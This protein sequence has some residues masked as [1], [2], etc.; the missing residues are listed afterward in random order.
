MKLRQSR[1]C[2]KVRNGIK[3]KQMKHL[4]LIWTSLRPRQWIKNV[5]ILAP[6]IFADHLFHL[7]FLT[8]TATA[9]FLFSLLNGAVYLLND[10]VDRERDRLH[11]QKCRRPVAAGL[12]S[13][14]KALSAAVF[15]FFVV[16]SAI[17][18]FDRLFFAIALLYVLLNLLY[19]LLL[20]NV[21]ICDIVIIALGFVL[22]VLIGGTV[23]DIWLSPWIMIM[24]FLLAIFLGL[25][26]RRAEVV[27]MSGKAEKGQTRSTLGDYNLSLLDQMI[28]VATATTLISYTMYV[29]S[30]EIQLKFGTDKLFTTV[31]FVVFGI[32][33]YL[34]LAYTRNRGENPAEVIYSDLP[35]TLNLLLWA[36]VFLAVAFW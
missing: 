2:L 4:Q 24:T 27:K 25:M 23:N 7:P 6:V 34:F 31:P 11:P 18:L 15:L 9:V 36:A 28:S 14:K 10:I 33:R 29:M 35:F 21:V 8:R 13:V 5:F 12:L 3:S 16:L 32:F 22:R 20:R 30:P 17:Y 26:K 1:H 19:S